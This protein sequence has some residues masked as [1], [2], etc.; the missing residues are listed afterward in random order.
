[1]S[2][3]HTCYVMMQYNSVIVVVSCPGTPQSAHDGKYHNL[4]SVGTARNLQ[5]S[6][7]SS[8]VLMQ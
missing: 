2:E 7:I 3:Y 8:I 4:D 6:N 5:Q 1:M